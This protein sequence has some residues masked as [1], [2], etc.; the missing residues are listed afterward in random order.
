[1]EKVILSGTTH[2]SVLDKTVLFNMDSLNFPKLIDKL[3]GDYR[4]NANLKSAILLNSL[5]KQIVL[6]TVTKGTEISS[7]QS[8]HSIVFKILE[9]RLKFKSR[10]ASVI[11]NNGELLEL[12]DK[13]NYCLTPME[14]SVLMITVTNNIFQISEN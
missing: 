2:Q 11:L 3:K 9:G 8:N 4:Q 5:E 12:Y 6:I 13:L 10:H 1:M 7:F 14:D